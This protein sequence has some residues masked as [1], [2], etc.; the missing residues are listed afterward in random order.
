MMLY[1]KKHLSPISCPNNLRSPRSRERT[2]QC[3]GVSRGSGVISQALRFAT[4]AV[5]G[6]P[7]PVWE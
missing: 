6:C 3:P 7:R 5:G 1:L 2:V 4:Q